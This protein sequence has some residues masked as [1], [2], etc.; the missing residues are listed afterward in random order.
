MQKSDPIRVND[1]FI[2]FQVVGDHSGGPE[3]NATEAQSYI[4][5]DF[6]MFSMSWYIH[7]LP[8]T[9]IPSVDSIARGELYCLVVSEQSF[10]GSLE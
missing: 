6:G 1:F 10:H 9:C 3:S 2:F 5:D 8:L 7:K 4:H